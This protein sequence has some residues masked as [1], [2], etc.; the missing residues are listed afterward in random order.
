M[1]KGKK[2]AEIQYRVANFF[3]IKQITIP[4]VNFAWASCKIPKKT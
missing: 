3:G 2:E 4:N 1:P